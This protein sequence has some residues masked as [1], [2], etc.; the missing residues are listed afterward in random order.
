[1]NIKR[2]FTTNL[3][4][5]KILVL[6]CPTKCPVGVQ[7]I[8]APCRWHRL[9]VAV[10]CYI[11]VRLWVELFVSKGPIQAFF[12]LLDGHSLICC[13]I[14][15]F[16]GKTSTWSKGNEDGNS[17]PH[18]CFLITVYQCPGRNIL[19]FGCQRKQV[20]VNMTGPP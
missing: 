13:N 7:L 19:Q 3:I 10:W 8:F 9:S 17:S 4:F 18:N 2:N 5:D 11:L 14:P 20:T 15:C 12:G 1:M 6:E 16:L